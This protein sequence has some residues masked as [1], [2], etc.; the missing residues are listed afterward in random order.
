VAVP[1][2]R[3]NHNIQ[4]RE[5]RLLNEDGSQV[6]VVS[7]DEAK[8]KALELETDL[9]EIAPQAVPPVVKLIDFKKFKYQL[10]KKES[11]EKKKQKGG[12]LKEVRFTPY[13]AENDF[14]TRLRRVEGFLHDNNKVRLVVKFTGREIAHKEFGYD[15]LRRATLATSDFSAVDQEPKLIG[16]QIIMTLTPVKSKSSMES[17][18]DIKPIQ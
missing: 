3:T 14:Q 4:A 12:E 13:M 15:L 11:A 9:V 17:A 5:V 18:G 16:R 6:G 8:K 7:L 1:F 10:A 2:Y